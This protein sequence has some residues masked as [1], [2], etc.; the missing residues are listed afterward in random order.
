VRELRHIALNIVFLVPG[1]GGMETYVRHLVPHLREL[2]PN[3]RL[4]AFVNAAAR[5]ALAAEPW[6]KGDELVTHPLLGRR[7]SRALSELTLLGRLAGKD[8]IELVHSL[9]MTAPLRTSAANVVT[10]PDLI[11][12]HH[13]DSLSRLTTTLWRVVV[14]RVARRADRILT[15][16]LASRDDMVSAFGLPAEKIDVVMLGPGASPTAT[17]TPVDE[18]RDRLRLGTGP[19]VL[20]F[21]TKVRH[22]NL[23]RLLEAMVDVRRAFPDAVLVLPGHRT[24]FEAVLEQEVER[25]GLSEGV[26]LCGW[27]E[28]ADVEGLYALAACF[29]FPSLREGFGLPVLEAMARG[30]P[31]ACSQASSLPELAGDAAR[32]FDPTST[33]SIAAA[34]RELL[35]DERLRARLSAAGRERRRQFNWRTTAE[36]TLESYDRA[37]AARR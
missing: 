24:P 26:R 22:K 18:L 15:F 6:T 30:V 25:L 23:L 12:L 20:T 9:G 14:P 11:W 33:D 35:G 3:L 10:I 27:L 28:Q 1:M 5:P 31:V 32:Y 19:V 16:S 7:Y 13:P 4:T 8:G 34:V 29:V 37:F 36:G 17:P 21:S 2:R